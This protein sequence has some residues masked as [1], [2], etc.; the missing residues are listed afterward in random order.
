[1]IT[2][3]KIR[4]VLKKAGLKVGHS[5]HGRVIDRFSGGL[6]V[7]NY[8]LKENVVQVSVGA[9]TFS[10][11]YVKDEIENKILLE[12]AAEVLQ[13]LYV[14]EIDDYGYRKIIIKGEKNEMLHM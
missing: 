4:S 1:M 13:K 6:E 14:I 11:N 8:G 5:Y 10:R 3:Q 12:K 2:H 7:K 9:Y